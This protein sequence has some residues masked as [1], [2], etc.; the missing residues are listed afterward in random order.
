[1]TPFNL[2]PRRILMIRSHSMGIG[3]VL[4]SSAAWMSLKK[5][6]P[7]ASLHLLFLSRH[8]GYPTETLVQHHHALASAQ[9]LTIKTAQPGDPTARSVPWREL[10]PSLREVAQRVQPDLIIDFEPHGLRTTRV[11][12]ELKR[13]SKAQTV[14]IGQFPGRGWLYDWVAPSVSQFQQDHGLSQPMDYTERDYVV[15]A[16]LGIE[17]EG[18]PISLQVQ[19]G[20]RHALQGMGF[21]RQ[22]ALPLLGL[23]IGCGTPDALD[24]RPQL[25]ELVK[26]FMHLHAIQPFQLVLTG[27]KFEKATNQAFMD[28]MV[29]SG[30]AAD[31]LFDASGTQNLL[32]LAAVIDE[33]DVF[34]SSDSGPYHMAVGLGKPTLLWIQRWDATAIHRGDLLRHAQ[35]PDPHTFVQLM[36]ALLSLAKLPILNK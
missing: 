25:D 29:Q 31:R 34:V 1:M 20:V 8:K 28:Q 33:A 4:R 24:R 15:L 26:A 21:Q 35:R 18:Q 27:A 16:A 19:A 23:N 12:R 7:E 17:R 5:R 14:G 32:E 2:T 10:Q 30:F 13:L 6:W 22:E 3:D 36:L 9:F 11:T